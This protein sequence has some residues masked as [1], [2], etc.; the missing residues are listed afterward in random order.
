MRSREPVLW[1][2]GRDGGVYREAENVAWHR[3]QP[4]VSITG[5]YAIGTGM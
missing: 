5:G 3:T 1:V 4:W 2:A